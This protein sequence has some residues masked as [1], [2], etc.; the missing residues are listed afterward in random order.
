MDLGAH[1][2]RAWDLLTEHSVPLVLGTV[3]AIA[4]SL[5][6]QAVFQVIPGGG[7]FGMVIG[8]ALSTLLM[9]GLTTMALEAVDGKAPA[10]EALFVP[11]K[12]RVL[13]YLLCGLAIASGALLCGVG[14]LVT[15]LLFLLAPLQV[16][17]GRGF[18]EAL[19]SSFERVKGD[20]GSH[21][22]V[23]G[24]VLGLNIV[25]SVIVVGVVVSVPLSLLVLA[26]VYRETA[27]RVIE[28]EVL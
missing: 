9:M 1:F 10:F 4:L 28:A 24:A 17:D 23:W 26:S 15:S 18:Q 7:F 21:V 11:F 19:R 6:A 12:E 5:A 20:F 25:G 22:L 14:V 3:V 16:V 13:D 8:T 2:K 27:P